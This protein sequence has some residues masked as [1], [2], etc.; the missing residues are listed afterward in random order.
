MVNF[1]VQEKDETSP[2]ERFSMGFVEHL[3]SPMTESEGFLASTSLFPHASWARLIFGLLP[4]LSRINR[5]PHQP[6]ALKDQYA[7]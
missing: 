7:Q 2:V 5:L 3:H 1:S 6:K 4:G